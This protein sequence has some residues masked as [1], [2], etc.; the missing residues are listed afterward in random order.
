MDATPLEQV[1]VLAV[2]TKL[3]V[4]LSV[5]PAVGL[6]TITSARAGELSERTSRIETK[7]RYMGGGASEESSPSGT[8]AEDTRS[9]TWHAG[10]FAPAVIDAIQSGI[11]IGA[12]V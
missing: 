8:Q 4:E 2:A 3:T 9:L 7:M 11:S 10:S 6:L 12:M 1:V 5:S